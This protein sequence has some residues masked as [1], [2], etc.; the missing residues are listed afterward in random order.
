MGQFCSEGCRSDFEAFE[1]RVQRQRNLFF[2]C[3]VI[4]IVLP[5]AIMFVVDADL[6]VLFLMIVLLGLTFMVFP[7]CTLE[8][9][10]S[11]SLKTSIRVVRGLGAAL[12]AVGLILML[13]CTDLI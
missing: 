3:F 10:E 11:F 5:I 1:S 9:A 13:L 4:S 2:V 12:T 6:A 8:A 7:F